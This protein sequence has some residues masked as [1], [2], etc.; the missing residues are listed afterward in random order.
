MFKYIITRDGSG[1]QGT[2]GMDRNEI[3]KCEVRNEGYGSGTQDASG[4]K[5]ASE[6][7]NS[8]VINEGEI[9]F[10]WELLSKVYRLF[11]EFSKQKSNLNSKN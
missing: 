9:G 1:M 6:N 8:I 5:S 11:F 4:I 3:G 2:S 7:T 10:E